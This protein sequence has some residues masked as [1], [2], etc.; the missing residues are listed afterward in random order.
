MNPVSER[1]KVHY[2]DLSKVKQN[3]IP[4]LENRI[5]RAIGEQGKDE[6]ER[7]KLRSFFNRY[8]QQ[9]EI[10]EGLKVNFECVKLVVN[11]IHE[12]LEQL[13]NYAVMP[14][15]VDERGE[16][17]R[18]TMFRAL[19]RSKVSDSIQQGII[20][21][22][23]S[24]DGLTLTQKLEKSILGIINLEIPHS[25][26]I[27]QQEEDA[28]VL[29]KI[30]LELNEIFEDKFI[31]ATLERI[32]TGF[33]ELVKQLPKNLQDSTN[34][35]LS[36]TQTL[37][38]IRLAMLC[39][40]YIQSLEIKNLAKAHLID[41][42]HKI[43]PNHANDLDYEIDYKAKY[44]FQEDSRRKA[45]NKEKELRAEYLKFSNLFKRMKEFANEYGV[46]ENFWLS[47]RELD[48]DLTKMAELYS[49]TNSELKMGENIFLYNFRKL[50]NE[51][52]RGS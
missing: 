10:I 47:L 19:T 43:D 24:K 14:Q 34:Y 40:D 23:T 8:P 41:F 39:I 3:V 27:E 37:S 32:K 26:R 28:E 46:T 38:T 20:C 5:N 6:D 25:S 21:N 29:R 7:E 44:P 2:L 49:E 35:A 52:R 13:N 50:E 15:S 22:L 31:K 51:E 12:F 33:E 36:P 11:I 9:K 4:A 18:H 42:R 16:S 45:E 1:L 48:F 30:K 17:L